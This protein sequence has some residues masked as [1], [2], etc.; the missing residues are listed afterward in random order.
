MKN[1]RIMALMLAIAMALTIGIAGAAQAEDKP[2]LK[3]L[4]GFVANM[5]P[6]DDPTQ[7]A[8]EERTGYK[9]EYSMLPQDNPEQKLNMEIA[10]GTPYDILMIS[11]DMFRMLAKQNALQPLDD[12]LASDG[13]N[14]LSSIGE[15]TWELGRFEG[16]T[17]G[18]PMMNE[19]PNIE[20]TILM[21]Q[22][23]LEE[24]GLDV[25]TTP[26]AFRDVL[27]AVKEKKPDM[28]PYSAH[29]NIY[30][31]TLISGF[32]FYFNWN[33]REGKLAHRVE[34][35]E[36][37]AYLA[38][39]RGLYE[40]GLID[41]DLAI[42]KS[43]NLNEKF[44]S[45]KV[46]AIPSNWNDASIQ[47]PALYASVPEAKVT[48]VQPLTDKNGKAKIRANRYLNKVTAIPK[49]AEHPLDAVKFMN[50]KL[51][52]ETFVYITL[53]TEGET[54]TVSDGNRYEPIMPIYAELRT[55][56][57]GYLNG[58]DEVK[59]ADMWLARTRRNEE[60]GKAFDAINAEY[61]RYAA[62]D[63]TAKM[64]TL[65]SVAKYQQSLKKA[66]DDYEIKAVVGVEKLEDYG[67]FLDQWKKDGGQE[68]IDAVNEWYAGSQAE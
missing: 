39:M 8:I 14:L 57:W 46:F 48:Y 22:D 40:E 60:L 59:Y 49:S 33:E 61:D 35:P 3:V 13:A 47:V 24:L 66:M 15:E 21:R 67:K 1:Q 12:M 31:E 37:Q 65:D 54:F 10:S 42:N 36:Y 18:I 23:V 68:M 58:I 16:K 17:Y 41:P 30:S 34:L 50:A 62:F 9:C 45:G 43:V 5:D 64:P 32:G 51:D 2:V 44:A 20:N 7:A 19:R 27:R 56:A 38:Y 63:P 25:P 55:N 28:I 11:P 29:T 53:G 4:G 52:P 26:E 6:N